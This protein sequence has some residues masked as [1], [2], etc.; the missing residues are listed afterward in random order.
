MYF[1]IDRQ[2][3]VPRRVVWRQPR[4]VF[5]ILHLCVGESLV[6]MESDETLKLFANWHILVVFT[7]WAIHDDV[8]IALRRHYCLWPKASPGKMTR[9]TVHFHR[10]P[11]L[12]KLSSESHKMALEYGSE[13]RL[14]S[15]IHNIEPMENK[16]TT[17]WFW[18]GGGAGKFCRDIL[19]IF[20]TDWAGLFI[21]RYTKDPPKFFW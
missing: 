4:C 13:E 11:Y 19:F 17:I 15:L 5:R 7:M 9:E 10:G 21:F 14:F 6:I 18:G 3:Y 16:G 20:I 1:K 12:C 8:K 2:S